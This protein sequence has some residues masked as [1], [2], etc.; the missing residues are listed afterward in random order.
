MLVLAFL[1]TE[2]PLALQYAPRLVQLS[3]RF[4]ERGV[5]LIGINSNQQDSITELA[6]YAK[7]RAINFPLLKDVGNVVADQIGAERMLEVFVFDKDRV[8]RYR[9]RIDDQYVVGRQ[10][11]QATREDL[12][13]AIEEV[14]SGQKV[15]QSA[16]E[17]AGCRIGRL[18]KP[19]ANAT[20]T[21]A[22]DVAP[23]LN[24]RC[25]ECH[26]SGEIAP[27]AL[28]NYAEV[29][30]WADTLLEV[31]ED[32]RM[33]PWHASPEH[34]KFSNDRRLSD[35]EKSLL[36]AW[37]EAGAPEGN[38]ADLPAPPQFVD[39]WRLPRVDQVVYMSD[40]SF[41][42][43]AEGAVS[44]KY[45]VVD[46]GFKEDKWVQGAECRPGNRAVVHHI[47]LAMRGGHGNK[48]ADSRLESDFLTATAPGRIRCCWP[49]ARPSSCRPARS[50]SFKC[51][52]RPTA[53]RK[54]IAAASG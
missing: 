3:E 23:L 47:I 13:V 29:A 35:D 21:Y 32:N 18:R 39:G 2:C 48:K 27:F 50:S 19:C 25:V 6:Q 31:V 1:G 34:G 30:G 12:A 36:R 46:P 9:G 14:L 42:V 11:K 51:T 37:V 53:R 20:V 33:P 41:S 26:R 15:S 52:T 38:P 43:P 40:A 16:T 49:T 7:E 8:V 44:Y 4:A 28:T 45:F 17:V 10:R 54:K 24:A 22:K 5:A